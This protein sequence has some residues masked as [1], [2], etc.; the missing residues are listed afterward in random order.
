MD[1]TRHPS[2]TPL[3]IHRADASSE[4]VFQPYSRGQSGREGLEALVVP[5]VQRVPSAQ[6]AQRA[7]PLQDDLPVPGYPGNPR[8]TGRNIG[9]RCW[10]T[11]YWEVLFEVLVVIL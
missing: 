9:I 10:V 7:H 6:A 8:K 11:G 3:S 5:E 2:V 1:P 4:V